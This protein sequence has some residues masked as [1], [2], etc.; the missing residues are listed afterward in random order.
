MEIVQIVLG[1]V[2]G[3]VLMYFVL[4]PK[5]TSTKRRND[6]IEEENQ[7]LLDKKA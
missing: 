1:I 2:I 3:F 7:K 6:Q 4:R 5:L